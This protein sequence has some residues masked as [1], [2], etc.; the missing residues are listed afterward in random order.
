MFHDVEQTTTE[1]T[2]AA[3]RAELARRKISGKGLSD[4]MGWPRTTTWRRLNGTAPWEVADLVAVA[5]FLDV[6]VADLIPNGRAA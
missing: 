2:A 3:V 6:P 1:R 5:D 4:A